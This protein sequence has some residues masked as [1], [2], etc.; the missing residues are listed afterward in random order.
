LKGVESW[1]GSIAAQQALSA[2]YRTQERFGAKHI[3]DILIGSRNEKVLRFKHDSLSVHGAGRD[4]SASQWSAIIRQLIALGVLAVDIEGFGSLKLTAES[5]PVLRGERKISLTKSALEVSNKS[6]RRSD[7]NKSVM[8]AKGSDEKRLFNALRDKR[9][10][11]AKEQKIPPYIIF[12]D[13]TLLEMAEHKPKNLN[14][15]SQVSGVGS[16]KLERYGADFLAVINA[17][18]NAC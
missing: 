17:T 15:L 2:V 16:A 1:D 9:M 11:L 10:A 5:R 6:A 4:Y 8:Q 14:E 18:T 13:K 3:I 12:H 7:R